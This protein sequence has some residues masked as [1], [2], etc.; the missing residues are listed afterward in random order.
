MRTI[1]ESTR[2][3]R[4]FRREKRGIHARY[5]DRLLEET[6][7]M[8]ANDIPLPRRYFDHPLG[9]EWKDFRDCHL[10]GDLVLIYRKIGDHMLELARLGSHGELG[11]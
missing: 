10:R 7:A 9:G 3:R 8:L 6:L 1:N 2:F 5:L 11:L 4:D